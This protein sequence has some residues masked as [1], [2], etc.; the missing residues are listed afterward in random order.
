MKTYRQKMVWAT[1][2]IVLMTGTVQAQATNKT[3]ICSGCHGDNGKASNPMY[4]N[5]AGQNQAYLANQ[6]KQ[7]RDGQR[8]NSIMSSLVTGLS[9][10]EIKE[11]ASHYSNL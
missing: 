4:P 2:L 7:F 9:D 1:G 6:L 5:L 8:T 10:D 11:I 3:Q